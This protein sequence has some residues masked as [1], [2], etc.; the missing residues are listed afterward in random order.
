MSEG[1]RDDNNM[2]N[3]LDIKIEKNIYIY[4]QY[5]SC[6]RKYLKN[7]IIKPFCSQW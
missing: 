6:V 2:Y 3:I 7:K 1:D 4:Q 5:E